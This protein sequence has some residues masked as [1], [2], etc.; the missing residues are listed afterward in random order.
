ML[1]RDFYGKNGS[2]WF[3]GLVAQIGDKSKLGLV[4]IRIVGVH[5]LDE[6]LCP[7]ETLPWA[8][9]VLPATGAH[10]TSGPVP[11]DWVY[12]F[13][14]DGDFGQIPTIT[15][16]FPGVESP[17]SRA[18]Y[19][20][21]AEIER[22]QGTAPDREPAYDYRTDGADTDPAVLKH[23]V[24]T[25]GYYPRTSQIFRKLEDATSYR[26]ARGVY[27]GTLTEINNNRLVEACD[28]T[29]EIK[30][31]LAWARLNDNVIIK[32]LTTALKALIMSI[33]G[34]DLS[35]L[36]S[37][38]IYYIKL[39]V[40]WINWI[41]DIIRYIDD[42][43]QVVNYLV[44]KVKEIVAFI[45]SLPA[46]FIQFL[47]TCLAYFLSSLSRFLNGVISSTIT[48][49]NLDDL[50]NA[51]YD[52]TDSSV[53]LINETIILVGDVN[54]TIDNI[55]TI[56]PTTANVAVL[57]ES[58]TIDSLV[59]TTLD[60]RISATENLLAFTVVKNEEMEVRLNGDLY[61][62][63]VKTYEDVQYRIKWS[64]P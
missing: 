28:V 19:E 15:H 64:T 62:N 2:V 1:S 44:N 31:A 20:K 12:G 49:L 7:T 9:V 33:A 41:R 21:V 14:Q 40:R 24:D 45:M 47:R 32:G 59:P 58:F 5:S 54:S 22:N 35:G 43:V 36:I 55:S 63:K 56:P 10:T 25:F 37:S 42:W 61:F 46:R 18:M 30:T 23:E 39:I 34:T 53:R 17:Q 52:L 38:A 11:G 8:Q 57:P 51:I 29:E 13:F 48:E 50:G 16:I 3:T 26:S 4:R 6:S 27:E 60:N